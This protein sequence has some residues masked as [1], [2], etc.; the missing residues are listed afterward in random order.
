MKKPL[1]CL[2]RSGGC[3]MAFVAT[4]RDEQVAEPDNKIA[5]LCL[6]HRVVGASRYMNFLISPLLSSIPD[7][8]RLIRFRSAHLVTSYY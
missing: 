7:A 5:K 4:K 6:P 1:S 3:G 8:V 2:L